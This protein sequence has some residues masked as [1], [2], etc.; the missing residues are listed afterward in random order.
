MKKLIGAVA[1]A[2]LIALLATPAFAIDTHGAKTTGSHSD[3]MG[4]FPVAVIQSVRDLVNTL[5]GLAFAL[6][7]NGIKVG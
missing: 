1:S 5:D 4:L 2:Y 3:K 7:M 6:T